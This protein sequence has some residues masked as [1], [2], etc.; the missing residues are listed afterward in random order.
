MK[1]IIYENDRNSLV[2]RV[3]VFGLVFNICNNKARFYGMDQGWHFDITKQSETI[4]A[5]H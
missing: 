1:R 4:Y 5:K 3:I 2:F